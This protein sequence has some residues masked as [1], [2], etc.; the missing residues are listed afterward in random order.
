[1]LLK[2]DPEPFN[3]AAHFMASFPLIKIFE[4]VLMAT[5]VIHIAYGVFLQIQN[6]MARPIGYRSPAKAD[7]SFFSKFMIYTG[8]AILIF[9]VIHFI[10]FYFIKLGLV[11]GDP[12]NFYAIAQELFTIPGYNI[13]YLI[14]FVLLGFHLYHAFSSAFQTIGLN[15]RIWTP[16]VK[17]I[18][19]IY[20][21]AI[22]IGFA[23]IP[24]I[25][26]LF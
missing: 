14:C 10:N 26:W 9:L 16:I 5:I 11:E 21:L 18:A 4:I 22:P 3:K 19:L 13:F 2:S 6:W 8:G 20:A 17:T 12:E 23:S 24:L 15:H 1:M 25:I 7:T